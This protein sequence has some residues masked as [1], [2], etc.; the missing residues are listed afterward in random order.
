MFIFYKFQPKLVPA[1][2]KYP[3][4]CFFFNAPCVLPSKAFHRC[5]SAATPAVA[6]DE[7]SCHGGGF[8]DACDPPMA[9]VV[10]VP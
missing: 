3:L 10:L 4:V 6:L 7:F 2:Y 9:V 8:T 5:S 1:V